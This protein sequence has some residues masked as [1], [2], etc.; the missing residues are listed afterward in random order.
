MSR[1]AIMRRQI[2]PEGRYPTVDGLRV[3]ESGALRVLQA[4]PEGVV[5]RTRD[6]IQIDWGEEE[7][8]VALVTA[9]ALEVRIAEIEWTGT[10]GSALSSRLWQR[11]TWEQLKNKRIETL[12]RRAQDVR[13]AELRHCAYCGRRVPLECMT[14]DACDECASKHLGIVH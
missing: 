14:L 11:F 8:I 6:A 2:D 7:G 1:D 5:T 13:D 4:R 9:E 12:L 10:H 3:V